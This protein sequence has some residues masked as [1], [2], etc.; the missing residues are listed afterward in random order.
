MIYAQL[1]R[2]YAQLGRQSEAMQTTES[3]ER[4]GGK[5]YK[6]L[7]VAADT[8]RILGRRDQA[9]TT[10]SRALESSDEDRLQVRLALGRLFAEEGKTSDAQQQVALGFA[11]AR[12]AATDVTTPEDYLNAADIL[13]GIHEYPLAQRMYGRAHAL[14]ADDAAVAVG[15]ANASLALGDTRSAELQLASLSD[16]P[17]QRNNYDFLVVQGNLYR[18]RG[19]YDRALDSFVLANQLDPQDPGVRAAEME[20][21]EE[22][23]RPITDRTGMGSGARI[24]PVLEDENIYQMDA[25]L[26]GVQNNRALL[27][28]PRRSI[29]SFVDSRFQ[30]RP[31]SLPPIQGF[32]AERNAR[33]SISF[34]SELLIQDRNTFDTIFNISVAPV[35]QFGNV[36][37]KVMP[38][39][40]YTIRRDTLAPAAMNQSLFRQFLYVASNPIGNWLSFSGNLI[41]EAGPF[42]EQ[43]LHSRDFSGALDFR[44]GRPWSRTALLTGYNAR[45]L[46]F[47]PSVHEYYQTISYAGL[48]HRF[49]SRIR[50]SAVAEFLR[51]WRV[52][53]SQ[54][55]IAQTFRPRFGVDTDFNKH[56]SLSASGSWSSGR[57]FHAYD[58]VTSSFLLSYTHERAL[59]GSGGAETATVTYPM[60]FS[61]G[62]EQQTFYDFP[63]HGHTQVVPAA[64]FTF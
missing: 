4:A 21:A 48:Q 63:G 14:G 9:M 35:V 46:L 62:L 30:F 38:G 24:S 61:F 12:V 29:E 32:I 15:M 23:G 41:R 39:L 55:A 40:Q 44:V 3:A 17:E 43:D 2:S 51:A 13:M 37:L 42:T 45:D 26:L 27:P 54:C 7:L 28:P 8:L 64:R 6:I 10:Y 25:R 33:G 20:L 31:N 11:E 58:N 49:G 60:R 57:S 34:P 47:G 53:G 1:G 59:N 16:D 5:D 50:V 52:E 22:E 18:Q 56:W 19:K 36:T